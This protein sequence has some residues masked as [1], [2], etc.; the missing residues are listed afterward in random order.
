MIVDR[1]QVTPMHFHRVKMEDIINRGG[2]NLAVQLYNS[3]PDERLDFSDVIVNT[4]G[5]KHTMQAGGKVIL[6]PGESMQSHNI[7][8]VHSRLRR[9]APS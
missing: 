3:T 7:V 8:T 4:D 5:L 1:N 6:H 2:G 9:V